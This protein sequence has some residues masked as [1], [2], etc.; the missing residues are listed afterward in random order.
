MK[1]I[2]LTGA[3]GMVGKNILTNYAA[4]DYSWL[5]PGRSK[6]DLTNQQAVDLYIAREKPNVIIHAAGMVGG[7]Q[8]NIAQPVNFLVENMR[9]GMNVLHSAMH[10]GVPQVLNLG[11]SC[12]YPRNAPNP[13]Q[14]EMVL[15]GELEPTNEGYAIAK[16]AAARLCDYISKQSPDLQYKTAIP[17]NLYGIYD[18][19]ELSRSHMIPAV[20]D[21]LHRAK[22]TNARQVD[23]WGD[24]L[25]RREF[26][27]ASDL[28][29][30]VFYALDHFDAMPQML[31]IG[32][33]SDITINDYYQVIAGVVNFEGGF[34]HDLS[35][36]SGMRQ[37]LVDTR[38]LKKF[39]WQAPTSLKNGIE[40][41]YQ[42]YLEL[43]S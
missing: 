29:D 9:M 19:F 26:M 43:Q 33:G 35:K 14:E 36:P 41:T 4:S 30:F 25:S 20:I 21:K 15:N 16:V 34:E 5:T 1:K 38:L 27:F 11:S 8:A 3:N 42:H 31:N 12:M 10:A 17:C 18:H 37:K 22:I 40:A 28:A 7:I 23:I 13:L 2:L 39:G 32:L 6:L 24:G